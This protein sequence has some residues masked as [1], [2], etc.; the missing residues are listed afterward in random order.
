MVPKIHSF[1]LEFNCKPKVEAANARIGRKIE[2]HRHQAYEFS[3]LPSVD[4]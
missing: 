1:S 4:R 3:I 2:R